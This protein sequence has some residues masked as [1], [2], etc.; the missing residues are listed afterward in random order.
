MTDLGAKVS[1]LALGAGVPVYAPGGAFVGVVE[2]VVADEAQDIFHGVIIEPSREHHAHR[3]AYREQIG[4]LH[5]RGVVLSVPAG[6]LH[7]PS[8]DMPAEQ[9]EESDDPVRLGLRRAWEW[10]IRPR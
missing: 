4:E 9:V 2:H 3:F 8:T 10:L 5:E 7:E 6:Q 1:Y